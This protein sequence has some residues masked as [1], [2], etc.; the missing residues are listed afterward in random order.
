MTSLLTDLVA[1]LASGAIRVVDLANTL[2]SDFPVIVLPS[3][4]GQCE[5]FRMETVSRYDADGPAWYWNRITMNEHTGT[6]FD[7][8]AHW[9]TGR[10]VPHGTVDAVAPRDFVYPAVVIDISAEAAADADFVVTRAFLEHWEARHG[11]IPP[12]HWILLRSDW[13]KRVGTLAYL[14]LQDD[15]AH[16]PGPDADAMRFLVHARDCVGLGVETVGTDAGQ[17]SHFAEPLP[18][19]SILHGNGRFGLQCLTNLDQLPTFGSVIVAAPLKIK[20][21]SGSPLRVIALM[22]EA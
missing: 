21:G 20:G 1:Q 17:A 9:I 2:S 10:D 19:H 22:P 6:H 18:A 14:N 7:A 15:G 16:S 11:A 13:S 4:F 8:P 12:R 5:P 3:E